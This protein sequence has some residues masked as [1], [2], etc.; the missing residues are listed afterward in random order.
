MWINKIKSRKGKRM[1]DDRA[2]KTVEND[3]TALIV[4]GSKTSQTV[5][6]SML[7]IY[8]LKKPL[9]RQLKRHNPFHLFDDETPL[10]KFMEKYDTSLF[11]FGSSTKKRPN[12]L[13]FGRTHDGHILDMVELN[14]VKY[15][16][17]CDFETPKVMLGTKPCICLEGPTFETDPVIKRI[18][19]LLVDFFKG[20][21]AEMVAE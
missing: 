15:V 4:K 16:P 11:L 18:G 9:V 8:M 13:V 19:N 20:P 6:D 3:K 12:T 14:I 7:D 1:L 10:E 5:V 21:T 17:S 2:P